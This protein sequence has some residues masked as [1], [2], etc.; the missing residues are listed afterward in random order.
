MTT[1]SFSVGIY[2]GSYKQNT[3]TYEFVY[4]VSQINRS[5]G[6]ISLTV[7]GE[8][9]QYSIYG[10]RPV[11]IYVNLDGQENTGGWTLTPGTWNG[12]YYYQGFSSTVTISKANS[13]SG[14]A[15]YTIWFRPANADNSYYPGWEYHAIESGSR[16]YP[17]WQDTVAPTITLGNVFN[18]PNS[19]RIQVTANKAINAIQYSF[20]NSKWQSVS[21]SITAE[22]GG[23]QYI[24]VDNN[25]GAMLKNLTSYTVYIKATASVNNLTSAVVSKSIRT[26]RAL[27]C[28]KGNGF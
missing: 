12:S 24:T 6:T 8:A 3:L 13:A 15:N 23:S 4:T 27:S 25:D 14:N 1:K 16:S 5:N 10:P 17:I 28:K 11:A 18:S 9:R 22:A 2:S 19:A 21:S 26:T 20:D 7:S